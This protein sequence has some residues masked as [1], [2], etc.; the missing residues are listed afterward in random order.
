MLQLHF[1]FQI[2]KVVFHL[3]R[4]NTQ[5]HR[6]NQLQLYLYQLTGADLILSPVAKVHN[7]FGEVGSVDFETPFRFWSPRKMGQESVGWAELIQN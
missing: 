3:Y 5:N 1:R 4:G 6:W 2:S 7:N